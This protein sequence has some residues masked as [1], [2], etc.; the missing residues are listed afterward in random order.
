VFLSEGSVRVDASIS[1]HQPQSPLGVRAEV[2][3]LNSINALGKA[4]G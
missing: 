2:K 3:N 1:V 4:I